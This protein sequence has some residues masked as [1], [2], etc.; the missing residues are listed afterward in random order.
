M[1]KLILK[2]GRKASKKY[3]KESTEWHENAKRS[4]PVDIHRSRYDHGTKKH[5]KALEIPTASYEAC[6]EK[7]STSIDLHRFYR[8]SC[9]GL[10]AKHFNLTYLRKVEHSHSMSIY[11]KNV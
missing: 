4:E 6:G 7:R 3:A 11:S 2:T 5:R 9:I 1:L 8:N 10:T